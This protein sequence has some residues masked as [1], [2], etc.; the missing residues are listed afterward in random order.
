MLKTVNISLVI[1]GVHDVLFTPGL[2][3]H[4]ILSF[5]GLRLLFSGSAIKVLICA[6]DYNDS[7]PGVL[8]AFP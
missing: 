4:W 8:V 6:D 2:K 3:E 7:R 1:A 5:E